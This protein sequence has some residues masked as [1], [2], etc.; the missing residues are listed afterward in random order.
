MVIAMQYC[1]IPAKVRAL[2][3]PNKKMMVTMELRI[4]N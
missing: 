1:Q 3:T 4:I 2:T